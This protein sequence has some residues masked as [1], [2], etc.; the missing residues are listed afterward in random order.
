MK[1]ESFVLAAHDWVP[2]NP[3]LPVLLY[4]GVVE[5]ADHEGT[6]QAF[7]ELFEDNGW[8]SQWRDGVFDYH[9]Y[10]S[11]AHEA[12]GVAAGSATLTIGGPGGRDVHVEAGDALVLPTGTGHRSIEANDDFLVVGA[13]PDGQKWDIC[14]EPPNEA[15]RK[16]M[17]DLPIPGADP[18]QGRWGPLVEMWR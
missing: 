8:P 18:V 17:A 16:R 14:R 12:L 2:N 1:V 4:R 13:Y 5:A 10:H 15:A 6:A 7:E 9:H 3:R 11:T